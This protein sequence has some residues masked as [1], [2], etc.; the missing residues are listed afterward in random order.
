MS[1]INSF[2]KRG[3]VGPSKKSHR[4]SICTL[5][6]LNKIIFEDLTK[7]QTKLRLN[8]IDTTVIPL[9]NKEFDLS[10]KFYLGEVQAYLI[11]GEKF[12]KRVGLDVLLE[13]RTYQNILKECV[14][15]GEKMYNENKI[16]I[17]KSL[18]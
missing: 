17:V 13:D 18:F 12:W 2:I 16:L 7:R 11:N 10:S 5:K 1:N 8:G 9:L 15:L 14:E 4:K 3:K 6:S